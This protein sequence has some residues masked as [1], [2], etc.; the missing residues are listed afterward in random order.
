MRGVQEANLEAAGL[1][2]KLAIQP[3]GSGRN[4]GFVRYATPIVRAPSDV[5]QERNSLVDLAGFE[6]A[7]SA[8]PLQRSPS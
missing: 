4:G 8:M 2:V 3:P 6:P 5:I 1:H 7:T